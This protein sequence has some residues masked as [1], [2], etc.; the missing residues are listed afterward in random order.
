MIKSLSLLCVERL[1]KF[2][3]FGP[4]AFR[5]RTN[6]AGAAFVATLSGHGER[7]EERNTAELGRLLTV[8]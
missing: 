1:Q 8:L 5:A 6:V 4:Y 3:S 2:N 7:T